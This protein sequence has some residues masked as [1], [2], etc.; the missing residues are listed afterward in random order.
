MCQF[1]F[2]NNLR[3]NLNEL[4]NHKIMK[5]FVMLFIIAL[6]V[7]I[8]SPPVNAHESNATVNHNQ[9]LQSCVSESVNSFEAGIIFS[10]MQTAYQTR[11]VVIGS[12]SITT[13]IELAGIGWVVNT[14]NFSAVVTLISGAEKNSI[15]ATLWTKE[16]PGI[17]NSNLLNL[18]ADSGVFRP[19]KTQEVSPERIWPVV[20]CD[21]FS[22]AIEEDIQEVMPVLILPTASANL[23]NE[24]TNPYIRVTS[25]FVSSLLNSLL[26]A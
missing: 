26:P 22:Q 4:L 10:G 12:A 17:I 9:A 23:S 2:S 24:M 7:M 14:S 20:N 19:L 3:Y 11:D 6:A 15:A 1:W 13:T 18:T 16:S 21:V 5:K 8:N 25:S